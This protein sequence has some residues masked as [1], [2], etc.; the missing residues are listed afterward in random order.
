MN[1][2]ATTTK[3]AL[4]IPMTTAWPSTNLASYGYHPESK[5]LRIKFLSGATYQYEDVPAD[6]ASALTISK[7]KGAY[8]SL[9]I[10]GKFK[11]TLLEAKPEKKPAPENVKRVTHSHEPQD[12]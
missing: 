12:S 11:T 7:S 4:E 5:T 8:V 2:T 9:N 10:K 3:P 6:V 1:D